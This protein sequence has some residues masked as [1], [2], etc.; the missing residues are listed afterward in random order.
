MYGTGASRSIFE[1]S[2]ME[3][4]AAC[5]LCVPLSM[6]ISL[7]LRRIPLIG[8]LWCL[9][10]HALQWAEPFS[11]TVCK[12]S[13]V[14]RMSWITVYHVAFMT[15]DAHVSCRFAYTLAQS[16]VGWIC[17]ILMS[18]G[19]FSVIDIVRSDS[20]TQCLNA[21][22]VLLC[23]GGLCMPFRGH[24]LAGISRFSVSFVCG[25]FSLYVYSFKY[26][27]HFAGAD[28]FRCAWVDI[29]V[30]RRAQNFAARSIRSHPLLSP[31]LQG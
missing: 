18:R 4:C 7:F 25:G 5:M 13:L 9:S 17:V 27:N 21:L 1:V 2:G 23:F 8:A 16:V 14:G 28:P 10:P 12:R 31:S 6:P 15:S 20:Y 26:S 11:P 19:M 22:G 30:S 29:R 24:I 3:P